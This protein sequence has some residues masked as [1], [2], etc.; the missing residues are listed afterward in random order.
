MRLIDADEMAANES[1]AYMNVQSRADVGD[2][3]KAV[4]EV[5][6]KKIQQLI[7]DTP[8]INAVPVVHGK[9][10]WDKNGMD[11]G[12]GAW[13]CSECACR[14][15]NLPLNSKM[16]PLAFSGSKYCPNCGAKMDG[17]DES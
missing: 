12:L 2:I 1:E 4:N 8:A 10:V 17:G 14:N 5:V 3:A 16:S 7:A 11:F 9:W 6:H 13:H 15:N